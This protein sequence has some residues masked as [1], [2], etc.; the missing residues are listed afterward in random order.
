LRHARHID[1][2]VRAAPRIERRV[3]KLDADVKRRRG[4]RREAA[5]ERVALIALFM[6]SYL[7]ASAEGSALV[8]R[9]TNWL[10]ENVDE[11]GPQ[12]L[13]SL[14]ARLD[15]RPPSEGDA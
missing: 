12:L 10:R 14:A 4:N 13:D 9:T 3:A 5:E 2:V 8:V 11:I 6:R 1:N 15:P 7:P